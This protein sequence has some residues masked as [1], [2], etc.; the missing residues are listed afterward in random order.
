MRHPNVGNHLQR[1]GETQTKDQ[2]PRANYR[3]H[4][5]ESSQAT[6]SQNGLRER[7][8]EQDE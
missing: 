4:H 3:R 5:Q 2:Q 6:G 7:E 8:E 1:E